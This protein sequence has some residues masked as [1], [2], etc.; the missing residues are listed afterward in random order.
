M[1][2]QQREEEDEEPSG[3]TTTPSTRPTIYL[4]T[5]EAYDRWAEVYDTDD[6]MLQAIDTR[7]L[8]SLLPSY[9]A[10]VQ[11]ST[12]QQQQQQLKIVDLGCGTGR[13]TLRLFELL[14]ADATQ[15]MVAVVVGLDASA[16]MLDVARRRWDELCG[17][18]FGKQGKKQRHEVTFEVFD[19]I[20]ATAVEAGEDA[21][22]V[23]DRCSIPSV[24]RDAD[25][26][27]STLVLEH[28]P[29]DVF[30]RTVHGM[31]KDG[32][33]LLLTNMHHQMGALSQ[34][35]FVDPLS[36][37][38]IRPQSFVYRVDQVLEEAE[39]WGMRLVGEVR[40]RGV[41]EED[42]DVLG[43]RGRKWVGTMVWFGMI[44]VKKSGGEDA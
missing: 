34:A 40:E 36:G 17:G 32:G 13:N 20:S 19:A 31:L 38:K 44:L 41:R 9:L 28:L 15:P 3:E 12:P 11:T 14:N 10:L 16:K 39:R 27:L 43:S 7:E 1:S 42:V 5:V 33:Y 8:G 35:G 30:F 24:A 29:L 37:E 21:D 6:N 26:V 23:D 22:D 25:G 4:P 18:S 2:Q